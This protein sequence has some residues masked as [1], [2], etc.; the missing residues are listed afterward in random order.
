MYFGLRIKCLL[1]LCN[2][3]QN[4]WTDFI[5]NL[6]YEIYLKSV[7]W[8]SP[9]CLRTSHAQTRHNSG[10]WS[11]ASYSP[12]QYIWHLWW[13][14][15]NLGSVFSE[16]FGFPLSLVISQIPSIPVPVIRETGSGPNETAD[17]QGLGLTLQRKY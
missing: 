12:D 15:W 11:P 5:K 1:L 9:S 14:K 10:C 16:L 3:N 2:F 8:G 17:T 7:R 4:V 6:K 13:K